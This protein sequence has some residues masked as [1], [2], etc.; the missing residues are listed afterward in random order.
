[1]ITKLFLIR[2]SN[3]FVALRFS[4]RLDQ[5]YSTFH[6]TKSGLH[7]VTSIIIMKNYKNIHFSYQFEYSSVLS[8]FI[9]QSHLRLWIRKRKPF[10]FC[11]VF[12]LCWPYRRLML[13]IFAL[14]RVGGPR[15]HFWATHNNCEK[16]KKFESKYHDFSLNKIKLRIEEKMIFLQNTQNYFFFL[17]SSNENALGIWNLIWNILT[18]IPHKVKR[19]F[20]M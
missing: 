20:E 15:R 7:W 3:I 12:F 4:F 14:S 5:D 19:K 13:M 17:P 9:H 2:V 8:F 1:M 18:Q 10:V 6:L 11:I 16:I